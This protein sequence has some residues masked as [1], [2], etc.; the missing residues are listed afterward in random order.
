MSG[1][2]N[3]KMPTRE[4][5]AFAAAVL[6]RR[7]A[8][9]T[10]VHRAGRMVDEAA[11]GGSPRMLSEVM[12]ALG[13][14][15]SADVEALLEDLGLRVFACPACGA[16]RYVPRTKPPEGVTCPLCAGQ[17]RPAR[18]PALSAGLSKTP[19]EDPLVGREIPPY[20]ILR[21]LR[22][23]RI[24][25]RYS[26]ENMRENRRCLL[27]L[28][29]LDQPPVRA[30]VAGLLRSAQAAARLDHANVL[31]VFGA[32]PLES[33]F[34]LET[35]F[36][37]GRSLRRILRRLGRIGPDEASVVA[38][39]VL[40]ALAAAH[41]L[42]IVHGAVAPGAVL[43]TPAGQV[44]LTDFAR[45]GGAATP[46]PPGTRETL[47]PEQWRGEAPDGRT[48][49]YA[50]GITLFRAIT[51]RWPFESDDDAALAQMHQTVPLPDAAALAP[52][53]PAALAALLRRLCAK[54][55]EE[56]PDTA[57]DVLSML[58]EVWQSGAA[59]PAPLTDLFAAAGRARPGMGSA[60][61]RARGQ[62]PGEGP[63]GGF[64]SGRGPSDA[65]GFRP[66]STLR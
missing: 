16:Q 38:A 19:P 53:L 15:R 32:G 36:V 46:A 48:D 7:L 6:R 13:H 64:A 26:A 42:G 2:G 29:D 24:G 8:S 50:L 43:L 4:D 17:H 44:K 33:H 61:G 41:A 1:G 10:Q 56:R 34:C 20:R 57:G 60:E 52:D 58:R 5:M 23:D 14:V 30:G 25:A 35:E 11:R 22:R 27:A 31:R 12:L 63:P 55:P 45:L 62:R 28:F 49:L 65:E 54:R 47:A 3:D 40:Q 66:R 37:R 21:L 59:H 51:G 39:G 9:Q 18:P